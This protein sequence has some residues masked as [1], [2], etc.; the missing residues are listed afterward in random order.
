MMPG[1]G[2]NAQTAVTILLDQIQSRDA[3]DIDQEARCQQTE[4]QHG[5]QALP[6][7]EN[8][9]LI[10]RQGGDGLFQRLGG[11]IFEG[12]RFHGLD[13]PEIGLAFAVKGFD[14]LLEILRHP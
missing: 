5:H 3:G 8:L 7:G 4:I 13:T 1:Q 11:E 2:A 9:G 10:I 6:T 12:R 14:A